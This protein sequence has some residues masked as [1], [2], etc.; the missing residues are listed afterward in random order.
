M[1]ALEEPTRA[2]LNKLLTEL[3]RAPRTKATLDAIAKVRAQLK[4][5]A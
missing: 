3:M 5:L 1:I 4:A 2:G